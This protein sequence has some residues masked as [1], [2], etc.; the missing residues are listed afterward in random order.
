V[1]AEEKLFGRYSY[2]K[3]MAAV[4]SLR[5]FDMLRARGLRATVFVPGAEAE[6]HPALVERIVADG[7]EIAAHG[8]A[9]EEYGSGAFDEAAFLARTHAS[10]ARIAGQAP[11]GWR[12]PHGRLS[13]RTLACL[14]ELGYRYDASFQDDDFPYGLDADGGAGLTE[15]PQNEILNDALLYQLRQA[16][17]R[18]MQAWREE[19][20]GLH[21]EA[22]FASVTLH[23]RSDYGSGRASRIAAL[24]RFLDWVGTLGH[25]RLGTCAQA[26][27]AIR[28]GHLFCRSAIA[29]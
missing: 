7:H 19:Y 13:Q 12:A 6:A 29:P 27:E 10:L 16:H 18:V 14:A 5:M 2:G 17:D 22:C 25:V 20:E 24:E 21:R 1:G 23:P 3:Y 15:L 8:W 9:M 11:R 4:G 28:E 26:L